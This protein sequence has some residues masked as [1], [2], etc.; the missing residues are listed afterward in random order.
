[1]QPTLHIH[2]QQN[3]TVLAAITNAI[4]SPAQPCIV[5]VWCYAKWTTV[6]KC[7]EWLLP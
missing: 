7:G 3:N 5:T 6:Q 2:V 4:K 1:M